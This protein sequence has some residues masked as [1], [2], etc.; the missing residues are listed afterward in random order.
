[1]MRSL[2]FRR[3]VALIICP[4]LSAGIAS[5]G[6]YDP[7]ARVARPQRRIP[8]DAPVMPLAEALAER[9]QNRV[10]QRSVGPCRGG[11]RPDRDGPHPVIGQGA[12][13]RSVWQHLR[14]LNDRI[15]NCWIGDLIGVAALF[16]L[17]V[18]MTFIVG[19]L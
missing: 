4:E 12:P 13:R 17:V 8:A 9:R 10:S 5:A 15:E 7:S 19:M 1:M 18:I 3:E 16:G 11:S 14:A 6:A 2:N